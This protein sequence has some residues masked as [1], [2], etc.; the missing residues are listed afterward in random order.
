MNNLIF[1]NTFEKGRVTYLILKERDNYVGVCLEFDL[2]VSEKT[3]EEAKESIV[4]YAR[5]WLKNAAK[6][7]LSEELLNRPAEKKYWEAYKEILTAEEKK[8]QA[9]LGA[10]T[11][12]KVAPNHSSTGSFQLPYINNNHGSFAFA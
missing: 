1:N 7:H 5:L 12:P 9:E 3:F 6:N 2:V 8:T 4:D 11:Q 10:K